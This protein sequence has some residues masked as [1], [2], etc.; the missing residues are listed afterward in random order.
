[1]TLMT[2]TAR[3]P[4]MWRKKS[5]VVVL[6]VFSSFAA[7]FTYDRLVS[8]LCFARESVRRRRV[9]PGSLFGIGSLV[10]FEGLVRLLLISLLLLLLIF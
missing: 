4:S 7:T 9:L 3:K 2:A 1:M 8:T 6:V 10:G 5:F